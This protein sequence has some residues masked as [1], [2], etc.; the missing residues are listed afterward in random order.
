MSHFEPL[1]QCRLISFN[2]RG[3]NDA[4][5]PYLKTLLA[6]CD[7]LFLQEH[8]LVDSQLP[9]LNALCNK[10]LVSAVSGIDNSE[11]LSGRPYGGCAIFWSTGLNVSITTIPTQSKRINAVT[12]EGTYNK[13]V[14]VNVYL[15][16]ESD[17]STEAEFLYTLSCIEHIYEQF[18]DCCIIIGGDFNVDFTRNRKHSVLL[19]SFCKSNRLKQADLF[20]GSTVDYTYSFNLTRFAILDHFI[21]NEAMLDTC[22]DSLYVLHEVDNLSDHDA[23]CMKINLGLSYSLFVPHIFT[24]RT[25]WY[26]ANELDIAKYRSLLSINLNTIL[27]PTDALLCRDLHCDNTDHFV[28]LTCYCNALTDALLTA[29]A[30]TI[31]HTSLKSNNRTI[32]G[33]TDI[34]QPRRD[35]SLFWHGIWLDCGRPREG[36]VASI[37]RRTRAAY[38][39]SI[40]HVNKEEYKIRKER[41]A[42]NLLSN[43]NRDFWS[44]IKRM[45][46]QGSSHSNIVDDCNNP[47]DIATLFAD[48]FQDLYSSVSYDV[49]DINKLKVDINASIS[50]NNSNEHC[51]VQ[52]HEVADAVS[53][54]KSNKNDGNKGL[55]SNH[56]K[57]ADNDLHCHISFLF[58]SM[59]V[60]GYV[61]EE[62]NLVSISPVPK[63]KSGA[64]SN[65]DNYRAIALSSIF[66][67][68]FDLIIMKR[69]GELLSTSE[70]QF[71]FK[72]K[73]STNM[74]SMVLKEVVDYYVTNGNDVYC[75][76]LDATKA[77]D[78][79]HYCKLFAL[80]IERKL[81]F[82]VIRLLLCMYINCS[83]VVR[84]NGTASL[85]FAVRNGVRQGG[86]LS[87][88]L[89][90]VYIDG[91]LCILQRSDVGCHIGPVFLASLA[92]ADDISLLSPSH[93]A[94]RTLLK[95]C[96]D[97]ACSFSIK[98]NVTKTKCIVFKRYCT[99]RWSSL[100]SVASPQFFI[101]GKLIEAVDQWPHLGHIVS[102]NMD[103]GA[104]IL[105][106]RGALIKQLNEVI[107]FF[108]KLD[109]M[110]TVK[111]LKSFC[112]NLYG[113]E[114]WQLDHDC[115]E[116]ICV[117]LRQGLR[118]L[119]HVPRNTHC[120]VLLAISE[121][122]DLSTVICKRQLGFIKSC[123]HSKNS[124]LSFVANYGLKY[125]RMFS[126][127]GRSAL[128]CSI[129]FAFD[130]QCFWSN[131]NF[132]LL[133]DNWSKNCT[134]DLV[135]ND[136]QLL[137]ELINLRDGSLWH[138]FLNY[139]DIA[140][141]INHICTD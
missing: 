98:F 110:T 119:W 114:L 78:R 30:S 32:P 18:Y 121:C 127:I 47:G 10:F 27:I 52:L 43:N 137:L 93:N 100:P 5:I 91:L 111:L 23:L 112:L 58:S 57:F 130:Y 41:I 105:R 15:P 46:G 84:W 92:Y 56:V 31:P 66:G 83:A 124:V 65:S 26:K 115:I 97:Y 103:D 96:E 49:E 68:L 139:D 73:H 102:N 131:I 107:C 12:F 109:C 80:L 8:W 34:V 48:R 59:L 134:S 42:S 77:F 140:L 38:H 40:R 108:D 104:D 85:S 50:V 138:P 118:R 25:A 136:A 113:C 129:K 13:F 62:F 16:F 36:V 44:E 82:V 99:V 35:E 63:H 120:D 22:I 79:V 29:A 39:Y 28:D 81:P 3:F 60:H 90:C 101:D 135:L 133:V 53:R 88:L 69:Y 128:Y 94:M 55:N 64:L 1:S 89:F 76:M 24:S 75:V 67:K 61:P 95:I 11:V 132:S 123:I 7:F 71:G 116:Q 2:C 37:M 122:L 72:P 141:L 21:L 51:L 87:P 125:G 45:R 74:C 6:K 126:S 70:L 14:L 86:I 117:A 9:L 106:G 54:L 4:K 19:D 33:W 20:K 17:D